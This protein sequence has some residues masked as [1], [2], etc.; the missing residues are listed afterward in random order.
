MLLITGC[1][2]KPAVTWSKLD[3]PVD[4][5]SQDP[6]NFVER[7]LKLLIQQGLASLDEIPENTGLRRIELA[8]LDSKTTVISVDANGRPAEYRLELT[9]EASF[10]IDDSVYQQQ[11]TQVGEYVFD[12]RDIL[13]YKQQLQQLEQRMSRRISQQIMFAFASRIQNNTAE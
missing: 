8:K 10:T 7:E 2:F 9:Q 12:V 13:A 4:V 3:G 1:G 6:Y 11:F 5:V